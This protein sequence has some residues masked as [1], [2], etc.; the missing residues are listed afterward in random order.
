MRTSITRVTVCFL[1]WIL[2]GMAMT[3]P[4]AGLAAESMSRSINAWLVAGPFDNTDYGGFN[5]DF[6][7]ATTVQP[8]PGKMAGD[9]RWLAFDDRLYCR[10]YDDYNDLYTFF[11]PKREGGPGGPN[12]WAVAYAHTYVWSPG[13]QACQLRVGS[14]DGF[15][16]WLNG[17][18][19][20]S[21]E[22]KIRQALKDH[23]RIP[24]TLQAGWNR[25][26]LKVANA[27]GLWGFYARLSDDEG[28]PLE[29]LEYSIHPPEGA[30]AVTTSALPKGYT[31]WPYV[32]LKLNIPPDV[33]KRIWPLAVQKANNPDASPWRLSAKGGTPPYRWAVVEGALP[34]GLK[35][36][37]EEGEILGKCIEEDMARFTVQVTDASGNQATADMA[38]DVVMRPNKWHEEALLGALIHSAGAGLSPGGKSWFG[39]P[40]QQ[41]ALMALAGYAY[42]APMAKNDGGMA[43]WPTKVK[44]SEGK[45]TNAHLAQLE[46]PDLLAPFAEALRARG[47]RFGLYYP[48]VEVEN[49]LTGGNDYANHYPRFMDLRLK[50]IEELCLNYRPAVFWFDGAGIA[51]SNYG[52]ERDRYN[53]EYDALYSTIKTFVPECLVMSNTGVDTEHGLGDIDVLICESEGNETLDWYWGRWPKGQ[54]G[55]NPKKMPTEVW[56]FPT[57]GSSFLGNDQFARWDEWARVVVTLGCEGIMCNLDHT[58]L[59]QRYIQGMRMKLAEWIRPR[60]H[61]LQ[62]TR[63]GPLNA[64]L[65]GYNVIKG[66]TIYLH[67]LRNE[68]GKYGFSGKSHYGLSEEMRAI[69]TNKGSTMAIHH[70]LTV[71]PL[72]RSVKRVYQEPLKMN[73][74]Y[75]VDGDRLTI[76]T[77]RVVVDEVDTI[78][79]IELE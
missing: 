14:N 25:L 40:E 26:L 41:V 23:D 10:N 9:R 6:I 19:V 73:L 5:R 11:H 46:Q 4:R 16:A 3:F 32:W 13:E 29:G 17:R 68:R 2:V 55:Y 52:R 62:G 20:A 30:L 67:I 31:D 38:I 72:T 7:G 24:I 28:R 39:E 77:N 42:A 75:E 12:E 74:E 47:M 64:G 37:G 27:H 79:A 70:K 56:R 51:G 58:W 53:Q 78:I 71:F 18:E 61:T 22:G 1:A 49:N 60:L 48:L 54:Q 45:S 44:T 35:V 59:S 36:D 21:V 33:A 76:D 66:D 34:D 15:K 43:Y 8:A 69:L 50:Q 57:Q 63:P 65:W